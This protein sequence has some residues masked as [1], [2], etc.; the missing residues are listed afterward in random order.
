M[1]LESMTGQEVLGPA[2]LQRPLG[3]VGARTRG[4]VLHFHAEKGIA[5][6][7]E[8]DDVALKPA[9]GHG[10]VLLVIDIKRK[11]LRFRRP[12]HLGPED[13]HYVILSPEEETIV[14]LSKPIQSVLKQTDSIVHLLAPKAIE[15]RKWF[16]YRPWRLG[17]EGT[18]SLT[19]RSRPACGHRGCPRDST[20]S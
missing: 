6:G 20:A 11:V 10:E 7:P 9:E 18:P 8:D 13:G 12:D 1:T 19:P 2:M 3:D 17:G 5:I 15:S 4:L 14:V 16:G